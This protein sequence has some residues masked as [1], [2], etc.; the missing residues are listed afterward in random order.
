MGKNTIT[1]TSVT[2]P[3][4]PRPSASTISGAVVTM[5]TERRAMAALITGPAT[6]GASTSAMASPAPAASPAR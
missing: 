6:C 5:G 2:V 4:A 1:A 3:A